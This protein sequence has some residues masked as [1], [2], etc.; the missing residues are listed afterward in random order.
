M[1]QTIAADNLTLYDLQQD[2][3]LQQTEDP[4]F[5]RVAEEPIGTD[6]I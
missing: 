5:F 4:F 1:V 3:Q 2:F 6:R